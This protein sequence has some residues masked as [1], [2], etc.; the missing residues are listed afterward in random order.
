VVY[1]PKNLSAERLLDGYLRVLKGLYSVSSIVKRLWGS[2]A[3]LNFYYPM[4][5]GFRQSA[6]KLTRE[7]KP[8]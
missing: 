1:Q 5:F 4:N 6:L 3:P 7:A 8:V 2:K